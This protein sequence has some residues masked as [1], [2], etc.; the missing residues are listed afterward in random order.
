MAH[1]SSWLIDKR[2]ML[3]EYEGNVDKNEIRLLNE[4]LESFLN[5]GQTP[6]HIISDNSRMGKADLSIQL[7]RDTFT[8]MKKP[9]WGWVI[10]VGLDRLIRF[11]AEVFATQFGVKIKIASSRE[12]AIALLK[13]LDMTIEEP[14]KS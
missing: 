12:E 2:I 8:A 13:K 4:E 1:K 14:T 11:F 10:F 5:E 7:A 9:G 3:L 6:V